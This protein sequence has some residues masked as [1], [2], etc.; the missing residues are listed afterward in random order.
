MTFRFTNVTFFPD[1]CTKL[2]KKH[3]ELDFLRPDPAVW[4][5]LEKVVFAYLKAGKQ[6]ET[7]PH[8]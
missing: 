7:R 8:D 6:E 5:K 2:N 3:H 4:E 1:R